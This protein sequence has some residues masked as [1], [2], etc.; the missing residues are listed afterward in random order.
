MYRSKESVG[1]LA[2][3]IKVIDTY[4]VM[5]HKQLVPEHRNGDKLSRHPCGKGEHEHNRVSESL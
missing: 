5:F 3:W 4:D 1:Q 2:K